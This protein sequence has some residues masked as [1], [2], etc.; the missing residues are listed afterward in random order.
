MTTFLI[1][2]LE[3]TA[4]WLIFGSIDRWRLKRFRG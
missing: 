4:L 1:I 2:L 3:V